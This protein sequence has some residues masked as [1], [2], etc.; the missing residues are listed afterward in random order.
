MN[1]GEYLIKDTSFE[2]VFIPEEFNEEQKMIEETCKIFIEQEVYPNLDKIDNMEE[3]FMQSL[4]DKAGELGILSI[5]IPEQ[6]GGMGADFLTSMLSTEA[7]GS[8][9]SFAVALSAHTGIG[10][11][12]ILYYGNDKQKEKY[13]P[14]LATGEKKAAY[15]LTEPGSGSDANS[16]KTKAVLSEDGKHYILNGQ[17][18]W[19]TNG[20]FADIMTVFAKIG[21]DK[22]LSAF[23]IESDWEGVSSNPEEKKMGIKGSSTRQ[24]FYN[25]VK[26][27]VENLLG[28]REGGFKI[29]LNILNVGRLKLAGATLGSSKKVI[30]Q[31]VEYANEREQFGRSIA[32]YGAIKNKLADQTIKTFATE[33]ALYRV[34]SD[35][36]NKIDSLVEGGMDKQKATLEGVKEFAS[37]AAILKVHGS[38]TLDFV[39][40]EGVQIYGGM[41]FSAEAPM[42]RAYRDSR[43]N[44]IFEG[45]NE[46]NRMLAVD[47]ILKKAMK[48]QLDLMT[49]ATKVA[50][51]LMAIPDFGDP[52][53]TLFASE[54]KYI[55]NFKKAI[56]MTAGGAVQKLMMSLS[57]EQEILMGISDMM[58]DTYVAESMLLRVEKLVSMRGEENCKTELAILRSYIYDSCDR[59][60]KCGKDLINSFSGEDEARMMLMGLKRFTK[61]ELFNIKDTKRYIAEQ[62][63]SENKYNL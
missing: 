55:N 9:H 58:M 14:S 12:P 31:S 46:I 61:H 53:T 3:G 13:I 27:P 60:N 52:D 48:G 41:G 62:L 16:G 56:L 54:K 51:E 50:G 6:Y 23:I 29:A 33:S 15:C 26:V 25:N 36:Q 57:K 8:G 22:N 10:T 38:E 28:E 42:E 7:T 34:C 19:I 44:R 30:T 37:E 4:L 5:S 39:V 1:G 32:K 49:H 45:T 43:I 59:I 17:K 40:D 24:I 63:I 21:D 47:I 18:M 20:G 35:V 2:D 11:L